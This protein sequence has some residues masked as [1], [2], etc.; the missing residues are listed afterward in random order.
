MICV[1]SNG[2]GH[3]GLSDS[4][5]VRSA[6]LYEQAY[7]AMYQKIVGGGFQFDEKLTDASLADMLGISRTPVREAVR[8][9]VREGLLVGSP[10]KSVRIFRPTL[11]DIAEVYSVRASLEGLAARLAA[12]NP[13]RSSFIDQMEE[14]LDRGGDVSD[15]VEANTC[16]HNLVLKASRSEHLMNIYD[17]IKSKIMM[18]RFATIMEKKKLDI[19]ID[20]HLDLVAVLRRGDENECEAAF[21]KHVV[22]AGRR[23][24]E[25]GGARLDVSDP[26]F[27]M[28]R[29]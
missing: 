9:L 24:L 28:F 18:C 14:Y 23:T 1:A 25:R 6:P 15:F 11:R 29:P 19:A 12:L 7:H 3:Q 8:Q 13:D 17:T 21:R 10:N 2:R 22:D 4:I 5:V 27:A 16:F 20:A 26:V